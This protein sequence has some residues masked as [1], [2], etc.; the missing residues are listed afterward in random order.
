MAISAALSALRPG[1]DLRNHQQLNLALYESAAACI[2]GRSSDATVIDT[3]MKPL[4][5]A[6]E[7]GMKLSANV[8][9]MARFVGVPSFVLEQGDRLDA[10]MSSFRARGFEVR[11]AADGLFEIGGGASAIAV[12]S[13]SEKLDLLGL[14]RGI[15]SQPEAAL[16]AFAAQQPALFAKYPWLREPALRDHLA[17]LAPKLEQATHRQPCE[18]AELADVDFA[19]ALAISIDGPV[20][21]DMLGTGY[22]RFSGQSPDIEAIYD[23]YDN[24]FEICR[25]PE[26][27][28]DTNGVDLDSHPAMRGVADRI[29]RMVRD[30]ATDADGKRI[31]IV[32]RDSMIPNASYQHGD[33]G[34]SIVSVNLGLFT[35]IAS[36]DEL[37]YVLGHELEHGHSRLDKLDGNATVLDGRAAENEVDVR[38][39]VYRMARAGYNPHAAVSALEKIRGEPGAV[40]LSKTHSV[41]QSR[42]DTVGV[43]IAALS[44]GAGLNRRFRLDTTLMVRD[45]FDWVQKSLIEDPAFRAKRLELAKQS[46]KA[47]IDA[48]TRDL[49]DCLTRDETNEEALYGTSKTGYDGAQV[50]KARSAVCMGIVDAVGVTEAAKLAS[51]EDVYAALDTAAQQVL[52]SVHP[53]FAH[54]N[55]LADVFASIPKTTNSKGVLTSPE[56]NRAAI[57]ARQKLLPHAARVLCSTR[58]SVS[59]FAEGVQ[60]WMH[61]NGSISREQARTFLAA[62]PSIAAAQMAVGEGGHLGD[63]ITALLSK[64]THVLQK[65]VFAAGFTPEESAAFHRGF[66]NGIAAAAPSAKVLAKLAFSFWHLRKEFVGVERQIATDAVVRYLPDL[67]APEAMEART[68]SQVGRFTLSLVELSMVGVSPTYTLPAAKRKAM[69]SSLGSGLTHTSDDERIALQLSPA[70]AEAYVSICAGPLF[71]QADVV[72]KTRTLALLHAMGP[73]FAAQREEAVKAGKTLAK[74]WLEVA[75]ILRLPGVYAPGREREAIDFILSLR[76]YIESHPNNQSIRIPEEQRAGLLEALRDAQPRSLS[77]WPELTKLCGSEPTPAMEVAADHAV[78]VFGAHLKDHRGN[79]EAAATA[80]FEEAWACNWFNGGEHYKGPTTFWS[81]FFAKLVA[82]LGS[83]CGV[84]ALAGA[85]MNAVKALPVRSPVATAANLKAAMPTTW[86][87]TV[88]DDVDAYG[89]HDAHVLFAARALGSQRPLH[90]AVYAHL[91]SAAAHDPKLAERLMDPEIARSPVVE[92]ERFAMALWQIERAFDL[93]TR[94]SDG[95]TERA[96]VAAIA[97]RIIAQFPE[98]S[99]VRDELIDHVCNA[100]QTNR[101]ETRRLAAL[102]INASNYGEISSLR[103]I[104][105]GHAVQG[106]LGGNQDRIEVL[107]YLTGLQDEAPANL[108]DDVRV[109]LHELK[110]LYDRAD[111]AQR[112]GINLSFCSYVWELGERDKLVDLVLGDSPPLVRRLFEAYLDEIPSGEQKSVLAYMVAKLRE[113]GGKPSLKAVLEAMGPLG[114]KAGQFLRTSG[115]LP[116]DQRAQ[117]DSFFDRALKPGRDVIFDAL[118]AAFGDNVVAVEAVGALLGAGSINYVVDAWVRNPDTGEIERAVIRIQR[119]TAPGSVDNENQVLHRVITK[120]AADED[121]E[122][123]NAAWLAGDALSYAYTTIVRRELD[124]KAERSAY[125]AADKAYGRTQADRR[126]GLRTH[127]AAPREDLQRLVKPAY[128]GKVSVFEHV[129]AISWDSLGAEERARI[130]RQVVEAEVDALLV[131]GVFDADGHPGNWL[132]EPSTGRLVRIDYAQLTRIPDHDV[133]ALKAVIIGLSSLKGRTVADAIADNFRA[134]F[135]TNAELPQLATVLRNI[136]SDADFPSHER[137]VERL[138]FIQDRLVQHYRNNGMPDLQLNLRA[139]G[140]QAAFASLARTQKYVEDI[141]P[142]A[143]QAIVARRVHWLARLLPE[144]LL[145]M[146]RAPSLHRD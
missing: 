36:D 106:K 52:A 101:A 18:R 117:L 69:L 14:R 53:T 58:Q 82:K 44:R 59:M 33:D 94:P 28:I 70:E 85:Y 46:M 103:F 5:V 100:L 38:S 146:K 138:M 98:P 29:A 3:A 87:A 120:L 112:S 145:T 39:V 140:M 2:A 30:L 80:F 31:R 92:A 22:I 84:D 72:D 79:V 137:F 134:L 75:D 135:Q 32:L 66:W 42:I 127:V 7:R 50:T 132:I 8:D 48:Y 1:R 125:P 95:S 86:A 81:I 60:A 131:H 13:S 129:Q 26:I 64:D 111:V 73:R 90:D 99:G 9:G 11:E 47:G 21:V 139:P 89:K 51:H 17:D 88:L 4:Q 41:T 57:Q 34:E 43:A 10:L 109:K 128:Q 23:P 15:A 24:R 19:K 110:H 35:L 115:A 114:I 71:W 37:A 96:T 141:G 49:R 40:D 123:R 143:Y 124:Q 76:P 20:R 102:K 54:P 27:V 55:T 118:D 116:E 77:L 61:M 130:A 91:R 12:A 65:L 45:S 108:E 16:Q 126:T 63:G 97:E 104:D 25:R 78:H 93:T 68:G 144:S 136:T 67:L 119:D 122:V 107:R 142:G 62:L 56:E 83:T 74:P 133:A 121:V 6:T 113:S 105:A